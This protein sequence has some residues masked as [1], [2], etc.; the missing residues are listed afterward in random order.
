[1]LESHGNGSR[2][3]NFMGMG[4]ACW[5]WEGTAILC[6]FPIPMLRQLHSHCHLATTGIRVLGTSDA[7]WA[8][9]GYHY[10]RRHDTDSRSKTSYTSRRSL[11][12]LQ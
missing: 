9:E 1:M 11:G 8:S 4:M 5:E 12:E 2:S 3:S 10:E 6:K 7:C